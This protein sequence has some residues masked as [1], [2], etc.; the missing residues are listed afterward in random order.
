MFHSA[1]LP[2]SPVPPVGTVALGLATLRHCDRLG[3]V[4]SI[5]S[6]RASFNSFE[7]CGLD[8]PVANILFECTEAVE[9]PSALAVINRSTLPKAGL[10]VLEEL[11]RQMSAPFVR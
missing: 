6:R 9:D 3:G 10:A 2:Q 1:L 11:A 4:P 5:T 8:E 7:V